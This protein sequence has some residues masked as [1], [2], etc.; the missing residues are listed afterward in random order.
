MTCRGC[1]WRVSYIGSCASVKVIPATS[2]LWLPAENEP[3]Q[4]SGWF[5]KAKVAWLVI[6]ARWMSVPSLTGQPIWMFLVQEHGTVGILRLIT[7]VASCQHV[8]IKCSPV[9]TFCSFHFGICWFAGVLTAGTCVISVSALWND[10]WPI[11]CSPH[12]PSV[13]PAS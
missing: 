9:V 4:L 6:P 11:C 7:S 8:S 1:W 5:L 3:E 12:I 2:W 10:S 13:R